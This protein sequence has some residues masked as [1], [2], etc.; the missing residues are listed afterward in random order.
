VV[1][2]PEQML[3]VGDLTLRTVDS[4]LRGVCWNGTEVLQRAYF[5]VRD[6]PW[7]TIPGVIREVDVER[8]AR[9][10]RVRVLQ[11]HRFEDIDLE[12]ELT[13]DGRDDGT[14]SIT[15]RA[16]ARGS[17]RYSKIGLNL[18][19]GLRTYRG[20][21]GR[22]RTLDG[23]H[24]F[25]FDDA[26]QP[27]LIEGDTLTAMF[28]HF[29]ALEV[30]LPGV[31]ASFH[32]QGDRFE[33]QDHRNWCDAN[34]KTYGTPLEY[35]FPMEC[36]SGDRFEQ[37]VTIEMARTGAPPRHASPARRHVVE[38]QLDVGSGVLPAIGVDASS[39]PISAEALVAAGP[40]FVR[41]ALTEPD[42]ADIV[43]AEQAVLAGGFPV[44][45]VVDAKCGADAARRAVRGVVGSGLDVV[46]FVCMAGAGAFSAFR[47]ATDPDDVAVWC[48]VLA[49]T[50]LADVPVFSGTSQSYN[51]I[52]RDR[53]AFPAGVGIVFAANAQVHASDDESVMQN[54]VALGEVVRDCRRLY[55]GRAIAISP[56]ELIGEAG[57][58]P[59]GPP[60]SSA[61]RPQDDPRYDGPFAAAWAVAALAALAAERADAVCLFDAS[62]A[63]GVVHADGRPKPV[64]AV[65]AALAGA[66]GQTARIARIARPDDVAVLDVGE[67]PSRRLLVANLRDRHQD[68]AVSPFEPGSRAAIRSV[69][70]V[71]DPDMYDLVT[72][73]RD[74]ALHLSLEPFAVVAVGEQDPAR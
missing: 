19:H 1:N 22:A 18:H 57:P 55:P 42:A 64:A 31:D 4:D 20:A 59:S 45:L 7:N 9:D 58:Y 25:V 33:M 52:A 46:R 17:F 38:V 15:T 49:G 28:A 60:R 6:A 70:I 10:F 73:R 14:L 3:A 47:G 69:P 44:E 41:V 8:R 68:V 56:L 48:D 72:A 11:D 16:L 12:C 24:D 26:I 71:G 37:I 39:A 66:G 61:D 53:P 54:A 13:F 40:S 27:Q 51:V 34:W 5:A 43:A 32:F 29:D 30:R 65:L 62:G 21:L 23:W 67:G 74:G 2:I 50:V 35:G 63:R 36:T